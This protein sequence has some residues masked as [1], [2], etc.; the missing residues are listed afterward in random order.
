[1]KKLSKFLSVFLAL[2]ILASASSLMTVAASQKRKNSAKTVVTSTVGCEMTDYEKFKLA[3]DRVD[4]NRFFNLNSIFRIILSYCSENNRKPAATETTVALESS[5]KPSKSETKPEKNTTEPAEKVTEATRITTE[6]PKPTVKPTDEP[7]SVTEASEKTT[8]P[9]KLPNEA[10]TETKASKPIT[11][12]TKAETNTIETKA[13]STDVVNNS[14]FNVSYEDEVIRLVN[15]ERA[16]YGL[17]PLSKDN[18]A[19]SVAHIRAK[20]IVQYFSHTRP[21]GTS[22][23]TAAKEQGVAYRSA[24]E[25]IAYGYPSPKQVV[26]GW[27]NSE[28]HR[29]N[30]LSSSY[31][32]IGVGC[33]SSGGTLYWSQFFI[34]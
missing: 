9:S 32:K 12:P 11:A 4:C 10:A 30:I 33:Y 27:M 21:D 16:N 23:F 6:A 31:T 14:E 29:K 20:E 24:G 19:V 25:N 7:Q 28:G 8:K 22:C 18:G 34:G 1:M 17:S 26:S 3:L 2:M 13:K 5:V 15:I